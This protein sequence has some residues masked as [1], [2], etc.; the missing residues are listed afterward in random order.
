MTALNGPVVMSQLGWGSWA[1]TS[2]ATAVRLTHRDD[3]LERLHRSSDSLYSSERLIA[4]DYIDPVIE[5]QSGGGHRQRDARVS[6]RIATRGFG[7]VAW[8][9]AGWVR[10]ARQWCVRLCLRRAARA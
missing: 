10:A 7:H 6:S 5:L 2:S 1:S 3:D 9:T 8:S 4:E